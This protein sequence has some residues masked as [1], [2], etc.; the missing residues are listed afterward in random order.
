MPVHALTIDLEDWHQLFHRRLTGE[1][2]RPTDAVVSQTHRLLDMLDAA[3]VRATFFVLGNVAEAHPS[4]VLETSRRGHEIAT[5][6]HSHRLVHQMR[7]DE[8]REDVK[9][10]IA[11]LQEL[12]GKPVI[13]FRAPEFSVAH[14]RHWCFEILAEAG[15]RYDSSVFPLR[16]PRYGIPDA[17]TFPFVIPTPSGPIQEYPLAT[18]GT[19]RHRLPVAGG[20]YF[21]LLPEAVIRSAMAAIDRSGHTAV[22][23]FHPYEFRDGLLTLSWP[24]W[25][26]ALGARDLTFTMSRLL[27][28][29][30]RTS[31]IAKR[32]KPLL[33]R[34]DYLPLGEI[35]RQANLPPMAHASP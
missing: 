9:R 11:V 20:S 10:S 29:N 18:W 1:D 32:L 5:H 17:S 6:S 16:G 14:L 30:L 28:H 7:P 23:Y 3:G 2:M 22:L 19:G 12:T 24:T 25:R 26:R 4:L 34:F 35:Y 27:L 31:A 21:R 33:T 15:I 8:F 13:G